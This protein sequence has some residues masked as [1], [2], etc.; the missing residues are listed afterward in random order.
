VGYKSARNR[1]IFWS[2]NPLLWPIAGFVVVLM[3]W[4]GF[5]AFHAIA[6][7]TIEN[8]QPTTKISN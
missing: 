3:I 4:K 2:A 8:G 1:V 5:S 6:H 7:P